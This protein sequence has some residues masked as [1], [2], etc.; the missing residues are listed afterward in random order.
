VARIDFIAVSTR[1]H[2]IDYPV[3]AFGKETTRVSAAIR[4]LTVLFELSRKGVRIE[5]KRCSRAAK[6]FIVS[7]HSVSLFVRYLS[8]DRAGKLH[9]RQP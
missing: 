9:R 2:N 7:Q 6:A 5:M 1:Q 3:E 4:R 8:A